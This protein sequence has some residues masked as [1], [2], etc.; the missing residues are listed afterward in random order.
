MSDLTEF[1]L[2]QIAA[3]EREARRRVQ[4]G[5]GRPG[6]PWVHPK[7]SRIHAQCEAFRAIVAEWEDAERATSYPRA[8]TLKPVVLALASIYADREGYREEWR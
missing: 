3:D 2:A 6:S 5:E 7:P 8:T 4:A 1:L